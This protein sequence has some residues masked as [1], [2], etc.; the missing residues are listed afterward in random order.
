MQEARAAG[1]RKI[2]HGGDGRKAEDAVGSVFLG[3]VEHARDDDLR[4]FVP[5]GAAE[6]ALAAR[7]L[8]ARALRLV[9]HDG[10][11][12]LHGAFARGALFAPEI[13]QHAA[14][15]GVLDADRAV[16]VPRRRDAA[17]AAARFVWRQAFIQQGIIRLLHFPGDNAVLDVHLPRTAA[18]AVYAM[19]AADDAIVLPA[20]AIELLPL[21]RL[22]VDQILYPGHSC[23]SKL[24]DY[25]RHCVAFRHCEAGALPG[26]VRLKP[27]QG[28]CPDEAIPASCRGLLR[29]GLGTAPSGNTPARPSLATRSQ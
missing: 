1:V 27:R 12:R 5:G 7:L 28:R 25:F 2:R 11:V 24:S 18:G 14:P 8:D 29:S 3:G 20:V 6:A 21:A 16:D 10:S 22:R 9:S 19:C 17:L 15:V 26:T 4:H 13:Q 23:S